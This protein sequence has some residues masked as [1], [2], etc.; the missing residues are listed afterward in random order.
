[1]FRLR[2]SYVRE[3]VRLLDYAYRW[4][5]IRSPAVYQVGWNA[6]LRVSNLT[7]DYATLL[8]SRGPQYG[9]QNH[10]TPNRYDG[11]NAPRHLR[12]AANIIP[13][14]GCV[15]LLSERSTQEQASSELLIQTSLFSSTTFI[16]FPAGQDFTLF[17]RCYWVL[18]YLAPL[19][20]H[21]F[22]PRRSVGPFLHTVA[23]L[24]SR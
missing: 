4:N 8:T 12:V 14:M 19:T 20:G 13:H 17:C 15:S 23:V 18:F 16:P 7:S 9:T 3:T 10:G 24:R 5:K 6:T 11:F 21:Y 22:L 2:N 1:M